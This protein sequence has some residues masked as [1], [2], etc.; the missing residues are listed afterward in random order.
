MKKLGLKYRFHDLRHTTASWSILQG[1]SIRAIQELL[2]HSDIRVTQIYAH[3]SD[4]YL[5]EAIEQTF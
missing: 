1:V 4:E 5:R 3:L 2:G